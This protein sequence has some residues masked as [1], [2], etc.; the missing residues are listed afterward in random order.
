MSKPKTRAIVQIRDKAPFRRLTKSH[1]FVKGTTVPSATAGRQERPGE[2][3]EIE[4][5]RMGPVS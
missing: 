5:T 2:E 3:E 1:M 4:A